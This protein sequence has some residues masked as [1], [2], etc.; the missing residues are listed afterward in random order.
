MSDQDTIWKHR[1]RI[2]LGSEVIFFEKLTGWTQMNRRYHEQIRVYNPSHTLFKWNKLNK[3]NVN[4]LCSIFVPIYPP[5]FSHPFFQTDS[6][7][8]SIYVEPNT[9][10]SW[11]VHLPLSISTG[12]DPFKTLTS[13]TTA[14]YPSSYNPFPNYN[15]FPALLLISRF[16]THSPL[17]YS[18]LAS[19]LISDLSILPYTETSPSMIDHRVPK[20]HRG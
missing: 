19:S 20:D 9:G 16:I 3:L 15:S 11:T 18:F 6:K 5:I 4:L 14:I 2:I 17:C 8:T 7:P 12:Y 13:S 10:I 1:T